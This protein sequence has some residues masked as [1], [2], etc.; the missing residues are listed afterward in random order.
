[1]T[2]RASSIPL[3]L[4]C[5]ASHALGGAGINEESEASTLGTALHD[6]M[7]QRVR[8]D[9][10]DLLDLSEQWACDLGDLGFLYRRA[11]EIWAQVA[12][13]FPD[14]LTER[15]MRCEIE[16]GIEIVGHVDVLSIMSSAVRVL[17]W[18]SGRSESDYWPQLG[19]YA[20]LAARGTG[21][22][23]AVCTIAWARSGSV[24]TRRF[25]RNDLREFE[26]RVFN[27]FGRGLAY[28]LGDHC[29]FCGA[30][31]RCPAQLERA[32]AAVEVLR[33]ASADPVAYIT[34]LAERGQLADFWQVCGQVEKL[35]VAG[36]AAVRAQIE[37]AGGE[38]RQNGKIMRLATRERRVLDTRA[39]WPIL[40]DLLNS[41]LAEAVSISLPKAQDAYARTFGRGGKGKAKAELAEKLQKAG[42]VR[43]EPYTAMEIEDTE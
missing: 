39:A 29:T 13:N 3:L 26:A 8:G 36:R 20:L 28:T 9:A 12:P 2:I 37:Q 19:A 30:R 11:S 23:E 34:T 21:I 40:A 10:P 42:A 33:G 1:M 43:T 16:G 17:D 35:I 4:H 5:S 41:G 32:S 38:L 24:E 27:A 25:T 14:A 15:E 22:D 31:Y 6:A 18:K 7:R